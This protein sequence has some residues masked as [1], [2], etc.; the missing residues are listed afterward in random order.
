MR[1]LLTL[2]VAVF[3][4]TAVTGCGDV[5]IDKGK[6][7]DLARKV[8]NSGTVKLKTVTCPDGITAKKGASFNC[9]LVYADGA[10]GTI[11]L[12]ESDDKGSVHTA[13]ADIHVT[14]P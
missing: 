2:L 9:D 8:A 3:A 5:S 11:T 7:E 13:T 10:K 6:A 4:M 1:R 14:G 12:Q